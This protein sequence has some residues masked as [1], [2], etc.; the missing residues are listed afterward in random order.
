[1]RRG[2]PLAIAA[3]AMTATLAQAGPAPA[4][5]DDPYLWLEDVEG[6][7][8]LAWV[9]EQDA[10]S[11]KELESRPEYRAIHDRFLEIYNSRR[12]IPYVEKRGKWL[13]NFWQDEQAPRG[14]WRRTT[15]EEYRKP[16][17]RWEVLVDLDK[18]SA[19]ENV[20]WVWKGVTCLRPAH[21][22]CLVELSRGGADAIE[23]REY[24]TV[25]KRWVK[26]GFFS[27]E[28]KQDV[29]WR[30]AN[31]IYISRDYGPGTMTRSG[32]PRIVKEWKRGTPLASAKTVFEGE[33]SDVGV[34]AWVVREPGRTYEGLRRSITFFEGEDYLREGAHWIRLETPRDSTVSVAMGRLFVRLRSDWKPAEREFRAGSLLAIDL[35]RFLSGARDFQAI[36][37]PSE[38]VSLQ[39]YS[40]TRHEVLLDLL[41]NV[42]GR[43][44]EL[45]PPA[46]P[47]AGKARGEGEWTRREIPVPASSS[48]GVAP[49]DRDTSDDFWL[50]VTGFLEPTTL[51]LDHAKG[52]REELKA[53][54]AFFD[55]KGLTVRQY[56]ATSKDG[57]KIPYFAVMRD[58][59]KLDGS[60]PTVL[61]GYGGFEISMTPSYSGTLGAGWLEH[62]GAW[63]LANI[64][65]G[66]EFGPAWH[67][68]AQRE[69]HQ[70]SFDDFIAVA[71]DAI[72]RGITSPAHLGIMGG[73]NGGLLVAATFIERPELFKAVVCQVPLLDMKRYSHLLAG[74]SWVAEYGDPDIPADWA[75]ISKYSP[76]QN[77]KKDVRYPRVFFYTTTRDDRVHPG[78]ARKMVA[79]MEEQGHDVLYFENTEGGHGAGSTP[80]QQAYMWA[81]TYTFLLNELK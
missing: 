56:E 3:A 60:T 52:G 47:S 48:I 62:G 38:R 26:G 9:E 33:E 40:A 20:K 51:Y 75:Y 54:P 71:E 78:H 24:D 29:A 65:G 15:L 32:Y 2:L 11:R 57:T 13:Y 7:R 76:Y 70:R 50:T 41:D 79:K 28:S 22:H 66:G 34:N 25:E 35:D 46:T 31:T 69:H 17:P 59:A 43:V 72:R 4:A 12:R 8:A 44:V 61:Y 14:L 49:F 45:T 68:A 63:L 21:R 10:E 74:D 55:A 30:D 37:E 16:S 67:A 58:G 18:L 6:A 73:S 23:V 64:R 53:L 5:P 81:L 27:P 42:N 77:V 36:F 80:S 19:D 39:D 1:M